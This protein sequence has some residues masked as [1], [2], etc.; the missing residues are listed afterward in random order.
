MGRGACGGGGRGGLCALALVAVGVRYFVV[1]NERQ[2]T[3]QTVAALT[4]QGD[5]AALDA[6]ARGAGRRASAA[7]ASN[8]AVTG[9]I[10]TACAP[11]R[12]LLHADLAQ[13][14]AD[15]TAAGIGALHVGRRRPTTSAPASPASPRPSTSSRWATADAIK[16]LA[17]GR[18][19]VPRG[20]CR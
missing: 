8:T 11:R 12:A 7:D 5:A 14:Q 16:S 15:T 20:R 10:A 18:R 6:P 19:A 3:E 1:R 13:T 2:Q 4:P 9:A 17:G